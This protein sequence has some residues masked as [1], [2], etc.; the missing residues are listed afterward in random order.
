MT[1]QKAKHSC[2]SKIGGRHPVVL[3]GISST[4]LLQLFP[5]DHSGKKAGRFPAPHGAHPITNL[6]NTCPREEESISVLQR[7]KVGRPSVAHFEHYPNSRRV[8]APCDPAGPEHSC[9]GGSQGN[10]PLSSQELNLWGSEGAGNWTRVTIILYFLFS[11]FKKM[12]KKNPKPL[13]NFI[14]EDKQ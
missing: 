12:K 2:G 3:E 7:R 10:C 6:A 9:S 1:Q 14:M 5:G 13:S 4:L 11:H 8:L